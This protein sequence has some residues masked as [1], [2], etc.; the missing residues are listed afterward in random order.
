LIDAGCPFSARL[1]LHPQQ[2]RTEEAGQ[3]N[4]AN[5]QP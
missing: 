2:R 4:A 1:L 5:Q 3:R